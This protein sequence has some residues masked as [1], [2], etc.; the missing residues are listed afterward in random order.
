MPY[1][2]CIGREGLN[3]HSLYRANP[4]YEESFNEKT[5]EWINEDLSGVYSGEITTR[6]VTEEQAM[7]IVAGQITASDVYKNL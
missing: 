3:I 5:K 2:Y 6:E 1:K 4:F 7:Q